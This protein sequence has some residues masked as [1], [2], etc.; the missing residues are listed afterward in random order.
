LSFVSVF[1]SFPSF[2]S[3]LFIIDLWAI[4]VTPVRNTYRKGKGTFNENHL[5][6]RI[7]EKG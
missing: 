7:Q 1:A 4:E 3:A 2:A 5:A 6:H